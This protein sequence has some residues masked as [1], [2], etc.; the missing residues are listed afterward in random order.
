MSSTNSTIELAAGKRTF[1]AGL[2][3]HGFQGVRR[4][5]RLRV[6]HFLLLCDFFHKR[7]L[8]RDIAAVTAT[9]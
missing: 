6:G 4:C 8:H 2:R 7:L 9:A 5:R 1:L 3:R